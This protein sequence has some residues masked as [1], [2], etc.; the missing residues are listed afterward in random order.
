MDIMTKTQQGWIH[1]SEQQ[2]MTL[3]NM[4]IKNVKEVLFYYLLH[5]EMSP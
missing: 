3:F 4:N 1:E 5:Y 2:N